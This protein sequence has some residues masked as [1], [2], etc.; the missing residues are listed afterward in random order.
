VETN[1][2]RYVYDG[3]V[4]LQERDAN[5]MP[6]VTYTR[7]N[8]LSGSLQGAGGIGG[9]LARTSNPQLLTCQQF[10]S[11]LFH[12][13][14][15]GNV[16]CLAYT[17]GLLAAKYLYDPFGSIIAQYGLL[18]GANNYRFSSKEWNATSGLYYY[19]YRYYEPNIQ[20]WLNRD[21][22]GANA[23]DLWHG[24]SMT[25]W[26][27]ISP[28][29]ITE[30][31]PPEESLFGANLYEFVNNDAIDNLDQFGQRSWGRSGPRPIH[32]YGVS[33]TITCTINPRPP[34]TVTFVWST[35]GGPGI[36]GANLQAC[37]QLAADV[38]CETGS[39]TL[40][41]LSLGWCVNARRG[42]KLDGR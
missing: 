33:T 25:V 37:T 29:R 22:L 18:A 39:S 10:A 23:T 3:S 2:I 12:A 1:E 13:D 15:C 19:L 8:D 38:Y 31:I 28:L 32:Y 24:K 9:L 35:Y 4:V 17:N 14:G 7:G 42:C 21:P 34:I 27:N 41:S 40:A 26:L 36:S 5:N 20:R 6:M 11:T 30:T 16:T